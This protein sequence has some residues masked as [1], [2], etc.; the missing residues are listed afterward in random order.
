MDEVIADMENKKKQAKEKGKDKSMNLLRCR[1]LDD[2]RGHWGRMCTRLGR[3]RS[4]KGISVEKLAR[5]VR[6]TTPLSPPA[7]AM[8]V[9]GLCRSFACYALKWLAAAPFCF[10]VCFSWPFSPCA[11]PPIQV[12]E[13]GEDKDLKDKDHSRFQRYDTGQDLSW[14]EGGKQATKEREGMEEVLGLTLMGPTVSFL[15]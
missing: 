11:H 4:R 8:F 10:S 7:P 1:A 13:V 3:A 2:I 5:D 14:M 12:L 15:F 6:H 9:P